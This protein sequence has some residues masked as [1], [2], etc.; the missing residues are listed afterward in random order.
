MEESKTVWP[1][2]MIQVWT[3]DMI[4]VCI[5]TRVSDLET[6]G[7]ESINVAFYIKP[8]RDG[9]QQ[10]NVSLDFKINSDHD[11]TYKWFNDDDPHGALKQ[12]MEYIN[13]LENTKT[14]L[15]RERVRLIETMRDEL[16]AE[17]LDHLANAMDA[18]LNPIRTNLIEHKDG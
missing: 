15:W 1:A 8:S 11:R 18:M 12:A 9:S 17:G 13:G 7:Y 4:Q 16:D 2:D 6:K 14:V 3:T 5:D 10:F